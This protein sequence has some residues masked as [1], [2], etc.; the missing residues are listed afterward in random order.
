VLPAAGRLAGPGA[1]AVGDETHSAEH[2]VVAMG[3][4]PVI[5]PVPSLQGLRGV[6]TNREITGVK[7]IPRCLILLGGGPTGVEMAQ[8]MARLGASVVPTFAEAFLHAC[9]TWTPRSPRRRLRPSKQRR[10]SRSMVDGGPRWAI[11]AA[12]GAG[13]TRTDDPGIMRTIALT[14][15]LSPYN[16]RVSAIPADPLTYNPRL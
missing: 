12:C 15:V 16:A 10:W 11:P 7:G 9:V 5:P 6:W 2:V 4:D 8:A 3:A 14:L 1:V 13:R